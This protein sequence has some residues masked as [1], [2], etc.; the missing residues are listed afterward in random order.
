M[1]TRLDMNLNLNARTPAPTSAGLLNMA[2]N[3]VSPLVNRVNAS[4]N[5][6]TG[7]KGTGGPT[8]AQMVL[9]GVLVVILVAMAIFWK[10]IREGARYAYEQIRQLFGA[11]PKPEPPVNQEPPPEPVTE[12]PE[13]VPN[14]DADDKKFIEKV[15]PGRKEVF[16]VS[17]NVFTYYDAEPLCKAL[18]AELATHDQ[19]KQ[20]FEQGADW[21]N[22]GWT[23]G[24]LALFPT[25]EATWRQLQEGPESDRMACGRPGLNGGY[26]DNADLRF[27]VNCYG[28]KPDQ[29]NHDATSLTSGE[30]APLSPEGLEFERKVAKFRTDANT[31]AILPWS[32]Q[33]WG[34]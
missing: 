11:T 31:L 26:F 22:Y 3:A 17:K 20:A 27:G 1:P 6:T 18:G 23:K 5:A 24:Q 10:Q 29:T 19:V 28:A 14:A 30:G 8:P 16:N 4:V 15:L 21:C 2:Q 7:P 12:K 25:Q 9:L 33:Q 34:A 32:K 13:Q